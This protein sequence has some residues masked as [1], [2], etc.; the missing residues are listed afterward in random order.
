V[1]H[2]LSVDN[3]GL[4]LGQVVDDPVGAEALELRAGVR[5]AHGEDFTSGCDARLDARRGVFDD[6][7]WES[8]LG[9]KRGER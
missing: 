6:D 2:D 7:A 4:D 1:E 3:L 8:E 5:R 9:A